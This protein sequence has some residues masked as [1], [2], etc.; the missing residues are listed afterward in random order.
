MGTVLR[1]RAIVIKSVSALKIDLGR[2]EVRVPGTEVVNRLQPL[3]SILMKA[4]GAAVQILVVVGRFHIHLVCVDGGSY[5]CLFFFSLP[6]NAL[7]Y[8]IWIA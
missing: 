8:C 3:I 6:V 4:G 1:D 7:G 2:K 5:F